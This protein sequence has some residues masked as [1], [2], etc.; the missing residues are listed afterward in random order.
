[1]IQRNRFCFDVSFKAA[2]VASAIVLLVS[3]TALVLT[4]VLLLT[5]LVGYSL[6]FLVFIHKGDKSL[7]KSDV[8]C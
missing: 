6:S 5:I 8:V 3:G 7:G 2:E 4:F 1:M